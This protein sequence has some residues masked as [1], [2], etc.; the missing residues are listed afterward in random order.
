MFDSCKVL[1]N[2]Y[3][4]KNYYSSILNRIRQK[5][6]KPEHGLLID[7]KLSIICH[8]NDREKGNNYT[9]ERT[10][11]SQPVFIPLAFFSSPFLTPMISFA[12]ALQQS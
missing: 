5:L 1:S 4:M 7:Y 2:K 12:F 10:Q 9:K 8:M 11:P 3:I 6:E